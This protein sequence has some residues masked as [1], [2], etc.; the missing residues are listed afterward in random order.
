MKGEG[1]EFVLK[2]SWHRKGRGFQ[3][4]ICKNKG[5]G[6]CKGAVLCWEVNY[7]TLV[8][9]QIVFLTIFIQQIWVFIWTFITSEA[10]APLRWC[11]CPEPLM[12][13]SASYKK[14]TPQR[15][16]ETWKFNWVL[17]KSSQI[18]TVTSGFIKACLQASSLPLLVRFPKI[19]AAVLNTTLLYTWSKFPRV[20]CFSLIWKRLQKGTVRVVLY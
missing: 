14:N 7:V 2:D 8:R 1:L 20:Q 3:S 10:E 17:I 12:Y 11:P 6:S 4:L 9:I 5:H 13:Y 18:K 19:L 16:M 15:Y